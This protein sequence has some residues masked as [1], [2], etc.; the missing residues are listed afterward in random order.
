MHAMTNQNELFLVLSALGPDRPGLVA[1]VTHYLTE[2]GANVEDSR[3]AVLGGEFGILVL[4]SGAPAELDAI[5]R[6]RATLAAETDLE[7]L[8]RRTKSPE[9][10]RR[11]ASI[12]CIVTVE[13]IDHEGIVRAVARALHNAGVNIVS[14]ETSA[15]EAPITG[16]PLFRMEARIDLPALVTVS[17]VR[18]A[19]AGV[20]ETEN[21]DIDVRSL[22]R[23]G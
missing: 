3:M 5:E 22:V 23:G 19:M 14:V 16:S 7:I 1:Q 9:E 11:S 12:P 6:E 2:R 13:A 17:H 18:K 15:Y 8:L 4:V 10:H 20:A 21:L